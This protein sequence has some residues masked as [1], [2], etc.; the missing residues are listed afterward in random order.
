MGMVT[1]RRN[2]RRNRASEDLRGIELLTAVVTSRDNDPA[3]RVTQAM[4]ETAVARL[5]KTGVLV[6]HGW[7]QGTH[8]EILD[9]A[10]GNIRRVALFITRGAVSISRLAA[11][12]LADASQQTVPG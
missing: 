7:K 3:H 2:P 4:Q 9:R 1:V 5:I 11:L 6:E 10:V 8:R 12:R